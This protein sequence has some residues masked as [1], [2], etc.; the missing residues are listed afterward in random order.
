MRGLASG[1]LAVLVVAA[2]AGAA[3][4][5]VARPS[6]SQME[7]L[8]SELGAMITYNMQTYSKGMKAGH[9]VPATTFAPRNESITESWLTAMNSF[10][11]GYSV[12][13]VDHFSGF[14]LWPSKAWAAFNHSTFDVTASDWHDASGQ[15]L[16][17]EYARVM[18]AGG[19]RR[20]IFYSV[21]ND[22]AWD[23]SN[24]VTANKSKQGEFNAFALAQL[25][26]LLTP[27]GVY[28]KWDEMW[29]DAGVRNDINP[30]VGPLI[31]ELIPDV[32]CHSCEGF[33]GDVGIRWVGNEDGYTPLPN[34]LAVESTEACAGQ[35]TDGS[36]AG[37]VFCPASCDTVLGAGREW[38]FWFWK[39]HPGSA[40]K[41]RTELLS[42]YL[43]SVGRGCNM[44]LNIAPNTTGAP[45]APD[46]ARYADMGDAVA[47]LF[48]K[49]LASQ[50]PAPLSVSGGNATV[51]LRLGSPTR[52][53]NLTVVVQEDLMEFGQVVSSHAVLV[54]TSE[55][56]WSQLAASSTIG[57][58]RIYVPGAAD[59][60]SEGGA[61][62]AGLRSLRDVPFPATVLGV[63]VVLTGVPVQ[64][65]EYPAHLASVALY[66]GSG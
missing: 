8:E 17:A 3:T 39:P 48:S 36:P 29:F 18:T 21:H 41:S 1:A 59:D 16:L 50:S 12:L 52:V 66:E 62:P 51:E 10:G 28:P 40:L 13:T 54:E 46:M 45:D 63:R 38:H 53:S 2:G 34:W 4:G 5:P 61:P 32:V 42:E 25:R 7:W 19:K 22:W 65:W 27:G 31:R 47:S 60:V 24:F 11:A 23:V 44:I 56:G 9:V 43:R 30:G 6:T 33:S 20:G 15:D 35:P 64:G 26:E 49:E 57:Y 55:G 58:K 14:S 37:D